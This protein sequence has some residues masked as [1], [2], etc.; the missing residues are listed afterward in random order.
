VSRQ[1]Q[2]KPL[3]AAGICVL[4]QVFEGGLPGGAGS[5]VYGGTRPFVDPETGTVFEPITD[6]EV[7]GQC[8]TAPLAASLEGAGSLLPIFH[9]QLEGKAFSLRLPGEREPLA[10]SLSMCTRCGACC[11]LN[12]A[13]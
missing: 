3:Q 6:G 8:S 7:E 5:C 13:I 4:L 9:A 10:M 11:G 2:H 1:M 12:A